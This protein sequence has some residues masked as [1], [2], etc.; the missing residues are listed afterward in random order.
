[1]Q[2]ELTSLVHFLQSTI[3]LESAQIQGAQFKTQVKTGEIKNTYTFR[4]WCKNPNLKVTPPAGQSIPDDL[5]EIAG[6]ITISMSTINTQVME[7][8]SSIIQ[9]F[10]S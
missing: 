2:I 10:N 5:D 6:E 9:F 3:I 7:A 8:Y 1:M 4:Y